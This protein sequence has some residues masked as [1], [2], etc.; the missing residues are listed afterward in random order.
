[1]SEGMEQISAWIYDPTKSL[2]GDK[3]DKAAILKVFCSRK[4]ECDVFSKCNSC[5]LTSG[6]GSCKYGR[7]TRKEGFTRRARNFHGWMSERREENKEY[8]GSLKSLKAFNRVFLIGDHFYLP[9][10]HMTTGTF[11]TG[12]PLDSKWTQRDE[13]TTE[14]LCKICEARPR[15]ISG[16]EIK[17]YQEKEVPKFIFDLHTFYPDVFA[18]LPPEQ[19]ARI[20]G[21]SFVGRKADITT[22]NPSE[23]IFAKKSWTWDGKV[24][25]GGSLI[26]APCK[27]QQKITIIPE[28]GEAVT[29]TDNAQVGPDTEF[30]D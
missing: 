7:K 11:G 9:Y 18:K 16:D 26:F 5:L 25:T 13:V 17:S 22:C 28:K 14:L 19:Q 24:L 10:S 3:S 2:F 29:I 12:C 15:S 6:L 20:D 4:S 27:G 23:M 21:M 30:L 8:I 1:M